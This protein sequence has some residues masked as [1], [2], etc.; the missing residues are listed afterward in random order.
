MLRVPMAGAYATLPLNLF[1][2]NV[3]CV[4]V[5]ALVSFHL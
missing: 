2:G 1:E 4:D 3:R 5:S